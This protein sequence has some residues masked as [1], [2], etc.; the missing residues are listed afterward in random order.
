MAAS[1]TQT[2]AVF[3]AAPA[4]AQGKV[5]TEG[6]LLYSRDEYF[7]VEYEVRTRKLYVDFQPVLTMMREAYFERMEADLRDKGLYD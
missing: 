7:R 3:S 6:I 2:C 4:G 1:P 5:L